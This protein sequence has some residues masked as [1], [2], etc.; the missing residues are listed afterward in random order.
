M[1]LPKGRTNNPNGRPINSE[2]AELREALAQA[3]SKRGKG[4]LEH[5]VERAYTEDS[6]LIALIKKI[7]PDKT[8]LEAEIMGT[9]TQMG[10]VKIDDKPQE[11]KVGDS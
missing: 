9:I 4:L 10:T 8:Q 6:V 5:F 11:I 3:K 2:A 1:G 7:L